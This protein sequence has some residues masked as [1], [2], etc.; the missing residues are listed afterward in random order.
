[1]P[2]FNTMTR[3]MT[4]PMQCLTP[5]QEQEL[6]NV[7]LKGPTTIHSAMQQKPNRGT[8][9]S[10]QNIPNVYGKRQEYVITV[11]KDSIMSVLGGGK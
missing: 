7:Q 6:S 11:I 8:I 10:K 3:N 2:F 4:K 1:M 9:E 5:S